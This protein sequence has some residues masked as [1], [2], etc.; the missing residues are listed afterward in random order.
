MI[1]PGGIGTGNNNIGVP[2]LERMIRLLALEFDVT[3]FQLYKRNKGY[4]VDGFELIDVYS[5]R[6]WVRA[7]KLF[8]VF[9]RVHRL[10]KFEVVHGFWILPNGFFA[11][12]LG[13]IFGLKSIVSIL[14]GDAIALPEINYG[15]LIKPLYRRISF[16]TLRKADEVTA[17]TRYLVHNLRSIGMKPR[18]IHIIPWGIDTNLFAFREKEVQQPIR[19]LH[20]ANLHPVKDQETLLRAF[21]IIAESVESH[22]TLIGEGVLESRLKTLAG[23]LAIENCITFLGLLP[24]EA[25][26]EYYTDADILLHTSRSEGQ[27]EVVTEAMSSGVVVCGTKVG[28]IY[29]LEEFCVAVPIGDHRALARETLALIKDSNRINAL[30]KDAFVWANIHSIHWTVGQT[31]G[32]YRKTIRFSGKR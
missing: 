5:S 2:V 7:L 20:I 28:L 26:P 4:S 12:A 31:G 17:L 29:D 32:C 16:W 1:I 8:F 27:S 24:Y 6:P 3:V 21:K 11:V 30:R 18:E 25:L 10:K 19:F 13:K 9:R 14:G 22:L 15:Q 23:E